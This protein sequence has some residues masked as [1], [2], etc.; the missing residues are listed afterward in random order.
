MK[1]T[2]K[3]HDD[4]NLYGYYYLESSNPKNVPFYERHGFVVIGETE[5]MGAEK[6]TFMIRKKPISADHHCDE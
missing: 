5:V 1:Y 6:A 2:L 4:S 3:K